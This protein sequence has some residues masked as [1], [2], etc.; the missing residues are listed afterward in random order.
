MTPAKQE[1]KYIIITEKD[2]ISIRDGCI[3]S[4]NS[5]PCPDACPYYSNLEGDCL[6]DVI[7]FLN[8]LP[9]IENALSLLKKKVAWGKEID[10]N[11]L[12]SYD[13]IGEM[14]EEAERRAS[15]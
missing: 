9:T 12:F 2:M 10:R 5:S 14:I 8:S 13:N 15:E 11:H 3:H 7:E 4:D 6:F 1:Q